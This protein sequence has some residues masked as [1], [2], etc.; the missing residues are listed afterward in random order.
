MREL[1][2]NLGLRC[3]IAI[4]HRDETEE[5]EMPLET[6]IACSLDA[7]DRTA[8]LARAREL[9][10]HALAGLNV[11]HRSALLRFHGHYEAVDALVAAESACCPFFEFTTTRHGENTELEIVAPE[12]GEP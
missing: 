8:R 12:G 3:T 1:D 2:L 4:P 11:G 7:E 5:P 6:P 9:G 10:A